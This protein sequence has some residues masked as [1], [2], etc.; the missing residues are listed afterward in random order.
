MKDTTE[1]KN[2]GEGRDPEITLVAVG[3]HTYYIVEGEEHLDQLLLADGVYPQPVLCVHF[4]SITDIRRVMGDG[5]NMSQYWTIHPKIIAR[6]RE[7][8]VLIEKVA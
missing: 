7:T 5:I 6:L 3:E 1:E 8:K 2:G 4:K